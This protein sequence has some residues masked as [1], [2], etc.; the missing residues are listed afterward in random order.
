MTFFTRLG[1]RIKL[2]LQHYT[3]LIIALFFPLFTLNAQVVLNT[4]SSPDPNS[5]DGLIVDITVENFESIFG[6]QFTTNWDPHI[7]QFEEVL[8][9]SLPNFSEISFNTSIA[10]QG[11]L[12]VSWIDVNSQGI[13]LPNGNILF[14]IRFTVLSN[15]PT[16]LFF[17]DTPTL[18]E[19]VSA[20]GIDL[21]LSSNNTTIVTSGRLVSGKVF[22]DTQSDCSYQ[23]S[24]KGLQNW[25][26]KI[27]KGTRDIFR[28]TN[29]AGEFHAYLAPGTYT[30]SLLF[31]E[32]GYWT[33]S[34]TIESIITIEGEND[35]PIEV[36]FPVKSII[37]C[38]ALSVNIST[39]FLRRCF[40]NNYFI[41]Y[42]NEGTQAA[43]NAY[44]LVQ[45]PPEISVA[46]GSIPYTV[47]A[48]N[49]YHFDIGNVPFN[50]R[51][52]FNIT[53]KLDCESTEIGQTHCVKAQ[54]FPDIICQ[55]VAAQWSKASLEVE[56]TCEGDSVRFKIKNI[57]EGN[58]L[59]PLEFVVIEDVLMYYRED[60]F[61]QLESGASFEVRFE[62]NGSTYRIE[63]DQVPFHPI[64]SKLSASVEGCGT[65]NVGT[66]SKGII[67]M[68]ALADENPFID[69]DC[70]E[71][72]GAFDPN[73]KTGFPNGYGPN[74]F[75][76]QNKS[77]TYHIRFQNTG[78]DTAFN[79]VVIDTLSEH[80]EV[81]T[82]EPLVASHDYELEVLKGNILKFSFEDI[83]LVDST[84]NEPLSHGFIRFEIDQKP[85][86]AL[87][88]IINNSAAIYFDFNK[89]V[90]TNTT[91]YTIGKDFIEVKIISSTFTIPQVKMEIKPNP[92]VHSTTITI[93]HP[94]MQEATFNL[95]DLS[96]RFI[97]QYSFFGNQFELLRSDLETGV[98]IFEILANNQNIGSGKLSIK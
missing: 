8:N 75:I 57:G 27:N 22:T 49:I 35:T 11:E 28:I 68:F 26:V 85:D 76:D 79:I 16:E 66:Y 18:I 32:N 89:P 46:S 91:T 93:D 9:F 73:D 63:T 53:I 31:P 74:H 78:T 38:P 43:E 72:I 36:N 10:E 81:A 71:N 58:M 52:Q 84:K 90:I 64:S 12:P 2:E 30:L 6:M 65:N 97:K 15:I 87:G 55:P 96:G 3:P 13:T 83:L 61:F 25:L 82:F 80:L 41:E 45:F 60:F 48:E 21:W 17:D 92:F 29:K 47:Q 42:A 34:C 69:E 51:G 39:P 88:T 40:E 94:E 70:R 14:S 67:N 23:E 19:F 59:A 56:G 20:N 5:P 77:L 50:A 4:Q 98:Y 44:I 37:E 33:S 95:F 54:I 62:A 86:V 24:E 7:L 1:S